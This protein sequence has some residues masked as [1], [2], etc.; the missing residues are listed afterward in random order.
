LWIEA[1]SLGG[2]VFLNALA[3]IL[4][5]LVSPALSGGLDITT[6]NPAVYFNIIVLR[7]EGLPAE[8][9]LPAKDDL[10]VLSYLELPAH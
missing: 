10:S 9:M 8:V 4:P 5:H 1:T 7:G 2:A 6:L 3:L